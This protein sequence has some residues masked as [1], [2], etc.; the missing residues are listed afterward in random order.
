MY[1]VGYAHGQGLTPLIYTRDRARLDSL[2]VYFR[3]LNVRLASP[4]MPLEALV[5]DYLRSVKDTRRLHR[6][7]A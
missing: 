6:S 4:E 1:E 5:E 7:V 3:T 2:P